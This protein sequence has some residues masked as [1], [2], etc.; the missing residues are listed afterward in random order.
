MKLRF[1]GPQGD[2]HRPGVGGQ[3][4]LRAGYPENFPQKSRKTL[5]NPNK[6]R[7]AASRHGGDSPLQTLRSLPDPLLDQGVHC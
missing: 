6:Q 1:P 5:S 2:V 4:D 7:E 3:D